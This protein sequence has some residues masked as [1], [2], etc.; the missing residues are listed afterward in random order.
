[1]LFRDA[2]FAFEVGVT[3]VV[4]AVEGEGTE[5]APG[6]VAGAAPG[7][8]LVGSL[9]GSVKDMFFSVIIEVDQK[10]EMRLNK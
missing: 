6:D 2:R 5:E 8:D 9:G 4:L 10:S 3:V 1:M 7:V